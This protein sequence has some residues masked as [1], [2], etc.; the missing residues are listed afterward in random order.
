[1]ILGK[2]YSFAD[3]LSVIHMKPLCHK[4]VQNFSYSVLVK[5]PLVDCRS[6]N[7]LRHLTVLVCKCIF[8]CFLIFFR[9]FVIGN[10]AV[11]KFQRCLYGKVVH[12]ITVIYGLC[13]FVAVSRLSVCQFEYFIGVLFH[14][15]LW[16]GGK[17]DQ[18]CIK[19][20]K[21][22]LIFVIYRPV[23]LV[24]DY[25]VKMAAAEYPSLVVSHIIYTSDHSLVCGKHAVCTVITV[26]FAQVGNRKI[27]QQVDKSP[28]CL[29]YQSISVGEKEYVLNPAVLKQHIAKSHYSSRFA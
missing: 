9:Q 24:A 26:F 12:Q 16:C 3:F 29:C 17:A 6:S 25:Q 4:N 7:R 5:H 21:N 22:I 13:Q 28:L 27:R 1:M 11:Y 19:I 10:A 15:I 23:G 14:F 20:V 8:V 2:D 18:R